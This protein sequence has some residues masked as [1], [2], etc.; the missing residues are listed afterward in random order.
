MKRELFLVSIGIGIACSGYINFVGTDFI[1]FYF[2]RFVLRR[3]PMTAYG[4]GKQTR[5]FQYVSD[6]ASYTTLHLFL[7]FS[8]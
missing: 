2:S 4:D 6:L 8:I 5:S 7:S 1:S 3:E